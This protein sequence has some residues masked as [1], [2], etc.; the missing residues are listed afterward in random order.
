MFL[1]LVIVWSSFFEFFHTSVGHSNVIP[2]KVFDVRSLRKPIYLIFVCV[3][4][5]TS[6]FVA[7]YLPEMHDKTHKQK[8]ICN[9]DYKFAA[10][11]HSILQ[12]FAVRNVVIDSL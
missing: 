6:E 9:D 10:N 7:L 5:L 1:L 3:G 4:V 11:P 8:T 12:E 2:I